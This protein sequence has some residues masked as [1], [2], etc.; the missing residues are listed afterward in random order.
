MP[1]IKIAMKPIDKPRGKSKVPELLK[2]NVV[3]DDVKSST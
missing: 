1:V 2:K 3:R